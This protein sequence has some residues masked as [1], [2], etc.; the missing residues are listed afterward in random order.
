[1][2]SR[3]CNTLILYFK[4]LLN[5]FS[6]IQYNKSYSKCHTFCGTPSITF[7]SE[8]SFQIVPEIFTK[9]RKGQA[10]ILI[11]HPHIHP[12]WGCSENVM[13][14][15]F[16][17]ND[18]KSLISFIV[19]QNVLFIFYNRNFS[20]HLFSCQTYWE[21]FS[22]LLV[23]LIQLVCVQWLL[24]NTMP[25]TKHQRL[26]QKS[27]FRDSPLQQGLGWD[28]IRAHHTRPPCQL[29]LN[30]VCGILHFSHVL[31]FQQSSFGRRHSGGR[32][33]AMT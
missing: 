30:H 7:E 10:F 27:I 11:H 4:P 1:M 6:T 13:C 28:L 29:G 20:Y 12:P 18:N 19:L 9:Q 26:M 24:L 2:R 14:D 16:L 33:L 23:F 32:L 17:M 25:R 5:K 21:Y 3:W 15:L 22:F 8:W 31:A